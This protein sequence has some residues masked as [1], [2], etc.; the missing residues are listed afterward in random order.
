MSEEAYLKNR[1]IELE[2]EVRELKNILNIQKP[3]YD[4]KRGRKNKFEAHDIESMKFYRFQNKT[5][6]EIAEI[7][8]CSPATVH[9]LIKIKE[10]END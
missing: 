8:K 1:I 7:F 3:Q 9:N 2:L 4:K 10:T 5:Y 6:R